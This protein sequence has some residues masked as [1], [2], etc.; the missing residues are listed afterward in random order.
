MNYRRIILLLSVLTLIITLIVFVV[1]APLTVSLSFDVERDPPLA[2]K[3]EV[4]FRGVD[5]I[6]R[7]LGI[8]K[9]HDAKGTFFVTG[10]IADRYPEMLDEI[11]KN[12]HEIGVHG[13]YFHDKTLNGLS[14]VDQRD[15]IKGTF[16][17]IE[18][19][20]GRNPS[21]YRATG[22]LIDSLTIEALDEMGFMYDSSVVPSIG[23]LYLYGHPINSP[24]R[25]YRPSIDNLF[26]EGE[27]G[28]TE[29]P[30][31][32]VVLNGNLDSLLGYQGV[33][34]TKME[35]FIAIV[36][37]KLTGKP[38]VLYLHPGIMT[39]LPNMPKNYRAGVELQQEFD[40]VL[41][42]LERFNADY[43]TM[44]DLI[45]VKYS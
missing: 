34:I 19:A 2:N 4:T 42:F 44:E 15:A 25:P 13:G 29:V 17:L 9:E 1:F 7:I 21:G 10:R 12:G 22:H 35:L 33:T 14:K 38:V 24:E 5:E 36:D 3:N 27:L 23:G 45:F 11:V 32:P 41:D 37:S 26:I 31:T 43:M 18:D 40:D 28:I 6:P 16:D 30:L 39:D 8:L 20:T